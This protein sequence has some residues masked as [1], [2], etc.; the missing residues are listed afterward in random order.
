[1]RSGMVVLVLLGLIA[2]APDARLAQPVTAPV[3]AE[4]PAHSTAPFDTAHHLYVLDGHGFVHP[5]A[6]APALAP[7]VTGPNK[8]V[9]YSLAL[10]ADGTD[11]YV[12]NA[13]GGLD[14]VGGAPMIETG[15]AGLGFGVTRE[16]VLA[17]WA[18]ADDP[19]GYLRDAYGGLHEF[20]DAPTISNAARFTSA[21]ARAITLL[22]ESNRHHAY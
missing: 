2:A 8:D 16:V 13:W 10:F 5:V 1:M 22:P 4:S 20:G 11:G 12:L 14:P 18:S 15:L 19:A 21:N 9:A 7:R 3:A 6:D 17:P